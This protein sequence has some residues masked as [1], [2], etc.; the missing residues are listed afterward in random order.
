MTSTVNESG[1][2]TEKVLKILQPNGPLSQSLRGFEPRAQQQEMA[3]NV[4]AAYNRNEIAMIE[5]GTG[6]GKSLAYLLP[7]VMWANQQKER[8]V[9]STNTITLQEQLINK[10]IPLLLR[11][12]NLDLKAVLVKGMSNYICLRKLEDVKYELALLSPQESEEMHK[13]DVWKENTQEG[14]RS[15]LSFV[16]SY[17]VWEKVCAESDT[18]N[19]NECPHYQNCHF[20]KARREAADAQLLVVNHHLLFADLASRAENDNYNEDA[21]LPLYSRLILDEAHNIEDIATEYFASKVSQMQ[22]LRVLG[23]LAAEKNAKA[24]G[25]LPLLKDR[26]TDIFR[27]SPPG[28]V[29][30]ILTRLNIDLPGVRRDLQTNTMEAF[31]TFGQFVQE[32]QNGGGMQDETIPGERKLRILPMHQTHPAWSNEVLVAARKLIDSKRRYIQALN[33]LET[34]LKELDND[35]VNDQT[36]SIRHDIAALS[37]RLNSH[38]TVLED[39]VAAQPPAS[40]V[41]WIEVQPLRSMTNIQLIDADLDI[42]KRLVNYLFSKFPT[43]VLCSATLTTN[44]Q[45]DFFRR[46]LGITP[47]LLGNRRVTQ[48]IY[49]SP[50]NYYQQAM[51]AVPSD[52]PSPSDPS[53]NREASEKIWEAIQASHGNAFVL[54]TSYKMMQSCYVQLQKRLE[55]NRYHVF[56]QGDDNRQSLLNRFKATDRSVLF[57]TDSFWEGVDVA[58][59]ALRCVII[60]KLPFKVP[61]EPIIQARTEAIAAR[62]GDPFMEYSLPNAIVK[63]KQGF[64]RLIRNKKDRGCI[65]CLDTRLLTKQYGKMFLDSLP[66]CKQTFDTGAKVHQAMKDFYRATYHLVKG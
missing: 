51:L 26:L 19:R 18:C 42:S 35:R 11:T 60:V 3:A 27:N 46:R 6:T 1:L 61:S 13:I 47:E 56:K 25:K 9:I 21:V 38:C 64:G 63:F 48:N 15:D 52:L 62:G 7:A 34:D 33:G 20:F 50:F 24:H 22:I 16:P 54:F 55:L 12:L 31:E 49:D 44:N 32:L 8:T 43:I 39:F 45:F 66:G 41:R 59:E 10:D 17:S 23:K 57:G 2:D 28:G 30:S 4:I 14:S 65:I 5:A 36:K 40:Q 53:F 29:T 37:K 58:G